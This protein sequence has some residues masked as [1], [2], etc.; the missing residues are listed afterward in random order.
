LEKSALSAFTDSTGYRY[1]L[2]VFYHVAASLIVSFAI[3]L[4]VI[5]VVFSYLPQSKQFHYK[6]LQGILLSLL[7]SFL[8]RISPGIRISETMRNGMDI[9]KE[10]HLLLPPLISHLRTKQ[11]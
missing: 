9:Q 2:A 6:P 5:R 3:I 7:L 8:A 4:I 11:N 1:H 10:K